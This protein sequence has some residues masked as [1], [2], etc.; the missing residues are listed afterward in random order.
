MIRWHRGKILITYLKIILFFYMFITKN[1]IYFQSFLCP[2]NLQLTAV[3]S[4]LT[5]GWLCCKIVD[6]DHINASDRSILLTCVGHDEGSSYHVLCSVGQHWGECR[7]YPMGG[8][9]GSSVIQNGRWAFL[10]VHTWSLPS[11]AEPP[12]LPPFS[13]P[14]SPLLSK[15]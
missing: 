6:V 4:T 11:H 1:T 9:R 10:P 3:R 15:Q 14:S 2:Y 7:V 5:G 12:G 8:P 13:G